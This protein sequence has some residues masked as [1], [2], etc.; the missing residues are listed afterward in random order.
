MTSAAESPRRRVLL[1]SLLI[2]LLAAALIWPLFK[3][4]YLD[5]WDSIESTFIADARFLK[6]HWPHP[7]WQPLWY[8]GT[9]F[10]YVYPPALRYGTAALTKL[11]PPILPVR[12]YHIYTA[13]FYCLGIAGVY[14]FVRLAS[15][16]RGAAWLA[17]AAAALLS[18]S[19]LFIPDV[20][21]DVQL[22]TPL[23]LWVLT[24]YG[25]GPHMTALALLP[26]ALAAGFR[27]VRKPRHAAFAAAAVC[28]ALLV[29]NNFYGATALAILFPLL[30]WGLWLT[31][32]DHRMWLRALGIAALAYGLTAFWLAPSYLRTTIHNLHFVS[33]PG[34]AWSRWV[35][36]AAVAL[37]AWVSDRMARGRPERAYP[38]FV[39]GAFSFLTLH[40]LGFQYLNF[41]AAGEPRRLIPEMDLAMILLAVEGLRCL[42]RGPKLARLGAVAIAVASFSASLPYLG[43][44]WRI[45]PRY[46]NFQDRLEYRLTV[47]MSKNHPDA[48][49]LATGSVRFWYDAWFDLAQLGGGSDQGLLN[50]LVIPAQLEA[51]YA[52]SVEP[53]IQWLQCL[54]VDAA[55]VH[56]E[57]S[58]EI[59][60]DYKF[61]RKFA[62]VLPV[63]YDDHHGNVIYQVPRRFP[64]LARVVE[65]AR[66]NSL[67]PIRKSDDLEN[68]RA[69]SDTV[70]KGPDSPATTAW[71][72]TDGM[73]VSATLRAGEILLVQVSYDP[74]WRAYSGDRPL[75]IRKDVLGQMLIEAPPGAQD[76][77]LVFE[78]P[79][80]NRVG[81]IVSGVSAAAVVGLLAA[82]R[83]RKEASL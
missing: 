51:L 80:E 8:G 39:W 42:W 17:A 31:H 72:G 19:Y 67:R 34:N 63:L 78:L 64:G 83:R 59:H 15:G 10:D 68:I 66:V 24:R 30:V 26:I 47:W 69:Y 32:R 40:V 62:G 53:T 57:R 28:C 55:I 25:E 41:R 1:D 36:L 70:E 7:L 23:R 75:V 46:P 11:Y 5:R 38:V 22:L 45:Y 20:R 81:R 60:H 50:P 21:E 44:P 33:G 74:A 52:E 61:P 79:L 14:L 43:D 35:A 27:A 58:E 29:S 18:P 4:K 48:R 6:D 65:E 73:R 2:F 37:F 76:I 9:R 82:G 54:G 16:S 56:E 13:F 12:A 71:E 3:V 49:T 77:R